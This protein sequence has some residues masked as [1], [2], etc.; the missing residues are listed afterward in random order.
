MA[1]LERM[2]TGSAVSALPYLA[3]QVDIKEAKRLYY[4]RTFLLYQNNER[5][6][7][8]VIK[9]TLQRKKK[10][11]MPH[12][13]VCNNNIITDMNVIAIEFNRYFVSIGH[14]LS[15]KKSISAFQ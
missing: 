4:H 8:A 15:E 9:E 10:H 3:T 14:S 5:K 2:T 12:E 11:E 7:W 6:T 13:F 1:G